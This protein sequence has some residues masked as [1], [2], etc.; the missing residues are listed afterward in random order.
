MR[1]GSN[2]MGR[3]FERILVRITVFGLVL[4]GATQL[5]L[6]GPD[7]PVLDFSVPSWQE[8]G[9]AQFAVGQNIEDKSYVTFALVK[10]SS[11]E[12][13]VIYVNGKP[14]ASFA[15]K[16]ATVA[17]YPGDLVEIDC[18][19]YNQPIKIKVVRNDGKVV[20]QEEGT[21]LTVNSD[22]KA[23]TAAAVD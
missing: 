14:R 20:P 5:F 7:K 17:L 2:R 22:R 18:A 19:F 21:I 8:A 16:Y 3:V 9:D 4:L 15:E 10:Q 1:L 6:S 12:K 13:A 11:L 23:L